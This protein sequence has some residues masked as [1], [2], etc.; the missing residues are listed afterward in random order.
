MATK[1]D[2][3]EVAALLLYLGADPDAQDDIEDSAFLYAGAEG[4]DRI[5]TQTLA[6]GAD[7]RSTN[8]FGGTALIPAAESGRTTTVQILVDA[9]VPVD[10]VND[11]GWTALHEAIIYGD[12]TG[13]HLET[14]RILLAAGADPTLPDGDGTS[15]RD[16]A[17]A[18]GQDRVVDLLEEDS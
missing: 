7:V 15:P 11:L 14:I 13:G 5:L 12:G 18:R 10:H 17:A 2:H 6:H 9:G 8:R 1:A 4:Y 16:L 3:P